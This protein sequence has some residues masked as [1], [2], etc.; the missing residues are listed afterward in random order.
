MLVV[1][2]SLGVA[3]T[4]GLFQPWAAIRTMRYKL[5]HMSLSVY[6][7]LKGFIAAEEEHVAALG[8]EVMD[9]LDF[10]FGL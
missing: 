6:G 2:N 5:E 8:E 9:S 3:F 4:L 7:D 10:D 1:T